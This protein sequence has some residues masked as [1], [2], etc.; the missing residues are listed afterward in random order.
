LAQRQ[1]E[2]KMKKPMLKTFACLVFVTLLSVSSASA[3]RWSDVATEVV[4][5][6]KATSEDIQAALDNL[7][8]SGGTVILKAG[9]YSVIQPICLSRD[10][11]TL[12]GAGSTTILRLADTAN[13]PVVIMGS[14]SNYPTEVVKNLR[15]CDL[16]IDG[17]RDNQQV[18]CWNIQGEGDEIRNNGLTIRSV[19]DASVERV[20]S[21]RCRSG[22]LVTEKG[23]R[24]L[25]VSDY[26]AWDNHFDGLAAYVTEDSLFTQM[27]LRD[28]HGAGLSLDH[29]FN[30]NTISET[31]LADNGCGIFMRDSRENLFQ[32]VTIRNSR[33]HGVFMSQA[34]TNTVGPWTAPT[35]PKSTDAGGTA[36]AATNTT[37]TLTA[38]TNAPSTALVAAAPSTPPPE[39]R[40]IVIP[41]TECSG[42]VFTGLL[43][44]DSAAAGFLINDDNC[45]NNVIQGARFARNKMG[46]LCQSKPG[47]AKTQGILDQ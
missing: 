20:R 31:I 18:E 25:T 17:N 44:T 40:W 24:R 42:N 32:G 22:G 37:H 2:K 47:L 14:T 15:V 27:V 9:V 26:A 46:G 36:P 7:P 11:L 21:Y 12:R 41:D 30:H 4:L 19:S 3:W 10:N 23:V 29:K 43:I 34:A 38:P 33:E 13:C 6:P 39:G 1:I 8:E 28:N 35:P 5:G 45:A 16:D